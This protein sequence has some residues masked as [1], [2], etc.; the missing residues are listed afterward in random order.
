MGRVCRARLGAVAGDRGL[1]VLFFRRH[2]G[3]RM[4]HLSILSRLP[5][6]ED[7]P[8]VLMP[9]AAQVV[10]SVSCEVSMPLRH[11]F[12]SLQPRGIPVSVILADIASAVRRPLGAS[13]RH[14]VWRA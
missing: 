7:A 13:A 14:L 6:S 4:S 10:P 3:E 2:M 12:F 9:G 11:G 5:A 1:P 8:L